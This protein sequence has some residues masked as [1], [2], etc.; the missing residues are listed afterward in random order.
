M[1]RTW[2]GIFAIV[3][4]VRCGLAQPGGSSNE[5]PG[6][7]AASVMQVDDPLALCPANAPSSWYPT[8][9]ISSG[10]QFAGAGSTAAAAASATGPV[11]FA[12]AVGWVS[13]TG[14]YQC[15]ESASGGFRLTIRNQSPLV[16]RSVV[17]NESRV[18]G[19]VRAL[20]QGLGEARAE[21]RLRLT[22]SST[23]VD[24][25]AGYTA[26]RGT[27]GLPSGS[28]GFSLTLGAWE[29][30]VQE[31]RPPTLVATAPVDVVVQESD[32]RSALAS[33]E[34]GQ[35]FGDGSAAVGVKFGANG[36]ASGVA[37]VDEVSVS[38]HLSGRSNDGQ[39][40]DL[41]WT[42]GVVSRR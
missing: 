10:W 13:T 41:E 25:S 30:R 15:A 29:F 20:H 14:V 27:T 7:W 5:H 3:V 26:T 38:Q 42:D 6:I 19:R 31:D 28:W 34:I 36:A 9:Q 33:S 23:Q 2:Q 1:N 37:L 35:G 18:R 8:F 24:L 32:E 11:V 22:G 39:G 16:T 17:R 12:G 40:I 4:V 21:L